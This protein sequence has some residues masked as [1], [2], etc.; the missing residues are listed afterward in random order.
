MPDILITGYL[1]KKEFPGMKTG[2]S[3][4]GLQLAIDNG[5]NRKASSGSENQQTEV[6]SNNSSR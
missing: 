2:E 5:A 4:D 6:I 3:V 1:I